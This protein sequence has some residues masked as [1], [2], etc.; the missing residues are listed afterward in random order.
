MASACLSSI[1]HRSRDGW[2]TPLRQSGEAFDWGIVDTARL[3]GQSIGP[4]VLH[5]RSH[6]FGGSSCLFS[7]KGILGRG[8]DRF[9]GPHESTGLSTSQSQK[10]RLP[11][12]LCTSSMHL[13]A[14][15][16]VSSTLLQ[17]PSFDIYSYRSI[18]GKGG[19]PLV[20]GSDLGTDSG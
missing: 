19:R 17:H 1:G 12:Y 13:S 9:V 11:D 6:L 7:S 20:G 10:K 2:V 16:G 18:F 14:A 5:R 8:V 4:A 15:C 3:D